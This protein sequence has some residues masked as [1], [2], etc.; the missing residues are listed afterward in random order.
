MK[1]RLVRVRRAAPVRRIAALFFLTLAALLWLT[2]RRGD[3]VQAILSARDAERTTSDVV[4]SELSLHAVRTAVCDSEAAARVEAARYA[5][6]GAAGYALHREVWH[7]LAAGYETAEEADA[8]RDNLRAQ[9]GM[10]CD[11]VSL[12]CG[13]VRV[14]VTATAEQ[15]EALVGCE[16]ALRESAALVASLS[17]AIDKGE[18]AVP[19]ALGVLKEQRAALEEARARLAAAAGEAADAKVVSPLLS[20]A[21]TA[22][23]GLKSLTAE[24]AALPDILFSGR[25]KA[26]FLSMRVGEIDYLASLGG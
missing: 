1:T 23:K 2:A 25:M 21:E 7:V 18:A 14:R 8:V 5:P 4:F 17:R 9:E 20:L 3:P 24:Q 19:Q 15:T 22:E 16:R 13:R 26:L 6:R 11:T 10:S 12:V